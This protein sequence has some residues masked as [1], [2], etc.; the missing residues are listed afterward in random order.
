MILRCMD[1]SCGTVYDLRNTTMCPGCGRVGGY[2]QEPKLSTIGPLKIHLQDI[3][4]HKTGN[5]YQVKEIQDKGII[6]TLQMENG[7]RGTRCYISNVNIEDG[8]YQIW[9]N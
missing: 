1:E 6:A 3:L 4:I 5:R 7:L 9:T 2:R 8:E